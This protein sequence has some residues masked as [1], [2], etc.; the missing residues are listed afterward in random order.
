MKKA[1]EVGSGKKMKREGERGGCVSWNKEVKRA[2]KNKREAYMKYE[3][4]ILSEE[5]E[6]RMPQEY[7]ECNKREKDD[8]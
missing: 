4:R 6:D 2:V 8:M 1:V 5:S 7:M 3:Q